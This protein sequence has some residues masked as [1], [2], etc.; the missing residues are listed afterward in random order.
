[1]QYTK[2]I[3]KLSAKVA[4]K[5]VGAACFCLLLATAPV[6]MAQDLET[7][8]SGSESSQQSP[9]R[10][11]ST[12]VDPEARKVI[13]ALEKRI[14]KQQEDLELLKLFAASLAEIER[15]YVQKVDRRRLIEAAIEGMLHDL[16]R[17]SDYIP[18]EELES[19]Q[20]DIESEYGGIGIRVVKEADEDY[21]RV[22]TPIY[23]SPSYLA[24]VQ[25]GW[26]IIRIGP[27]SA[28][29]FSVPQAIEKMKGKIGSEVS[30]TF[31]DPA[32]AKE[33]P[34]KLKRSLVHVQT[35]LGDQ[36][37]PDDRWDFFLHREDL[38]DL[39]IGYVRITSFGR[40]TVQELKQAVRELLDGGMQGLILDLRFNPGGLLPAAI[41]TCDL[42]VDRGL[43]V[44][45]ESRER[46]SRKW[47]ARKTGS[48]TG[49]PL[50]VLVNGRSASASE[51]VAACLKDAQRAT[52][53]GQRT[54]GKGSV[55]NIVLLENGKSA[56]KLT[57]AAYFRP[58]GKNI[59]RLAK[60]TETDDWGVRPT[61]G[62]EVILD[63]EE[64][65]K[66][67]QN[68]QQRDII[69]PKESRGTKPP[70]EFEKF[71]D[72]QL[73]RAID[74]IKNQMKVNSESSAK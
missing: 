63:S 28:K 26:Q 69:L 43:I 27:E 57:T 48:L 14:R 55:Q 72:R 58:N 73:N 11:L 24:G 62:Y 71:E 45:T 30:V 66:Y 38:Q 65:Q 10:K 29:G 19:F 52:I 12:D 53:V 61:K 6:L 33:Y 17:Y 8:R 70:E 7:K 64:E 35:V 16:D 41:E 20:S 36:R 47:V 9:A 34:L 74:A 15:S 37:K 1:M 39:N 50:A 32:A 68:R 60:H 13:E 44:R 56:M 31:R 4:L 3:G 49:F 23:G 2:T 59:S 21:I 25:S 18:P 51:I 5:L 40:Q 42:F 22:T 46:G 54:F 67:F